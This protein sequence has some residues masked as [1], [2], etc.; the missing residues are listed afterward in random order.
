MRFLI[1]LLCISCKDIY[2]TREVNSDLKTVD[3]Y[4]YYKYTNKKGET[5]CLMERHSYAV[6]I[7]CS[8]Y[9]GIE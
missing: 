8:F 2:K 3:N 4:Y 6:I 5:Y 1:L 7:P 9:E